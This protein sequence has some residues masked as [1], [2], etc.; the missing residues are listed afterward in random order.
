METLLFIVL[1]AVIAYVFMNSQRVK[2]ETRTWVEESDDFSK[3]IHYKKR[4]INTC[5]YTESSTYEL[6]YCK[7]AELTQLLLFKHKNKLMPAEASQEVESHFDRYFEEESH[8]WRIRKALRIEDLSKETILVLAMLSL[9]G[10]N[11]HDGKKISQNRFFTNRAV[12]YLIHEK[13]YWNALLAKALILKYGF[14]ESLPPQTEEA[15]SLLEKLQSGHTDIYEEL[16]GLDE[17]RG[18][19]NIKTKHPS[20]VSNTWRSHQELERLL[21]NYHP[22]NING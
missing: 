19:E 5:A 9:N 12:E 18:L 10:L 16:R 20:H 8:D 21:A 1:G 13:N 7:V 6:L 17:L 11:K 15:R 14:Q 2:Q 4:I 22:D 3:F